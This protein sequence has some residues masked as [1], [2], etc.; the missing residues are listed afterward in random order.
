[1]ELLQ[2]LDDPRN[3]I[4]LHIDA[5]SDLDMQVLDWSPTHSRLQLITPMKVYWG[6]YSQVACEMKLLEEAFR[7][8][9]YSYY[10]LMTGATFTLKTQ[11]EIHE[12]FRKNQ[13]TE[14]IKIE[15]P[16][17]DDRFTCINL[18]TKAGKH[19]GTGRNPLRY[20]EAAM[21]K[22]FNSAQKT[23]GYDRFAKFGMVFQRGYAYWSIT[24]ALAEYVL[25]QK[26]LI[27]KMTKYT[28]SGDEMFMHTIAY[29]S[30]FK[31]RIQKNEKGEQVPDI[32]ASTWGLESHGKQRPEHCFIKEDLEMLMESGCVFGLKFDGPD[33]MWLIRQI[34]ERKN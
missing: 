34:K 25:S 12:I 14:H 31:D 8:G 18:F 13:G 30:P 33:G 26:E 23:L 28:R 7:R 11:D 10:H 9:G 29:N 2:S 22:I 17:C 19:W 20:L 6:D 1:M 16:I 5:K 3:D 24:P 15:A 32:W 21:R 27:R 4:Y